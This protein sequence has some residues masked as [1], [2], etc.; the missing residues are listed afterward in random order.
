MKAPQEQDGIILGSRKI[1]AIQ[2]F[3]RLPTHLLEKLGNL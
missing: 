3:I 2:K 1:E